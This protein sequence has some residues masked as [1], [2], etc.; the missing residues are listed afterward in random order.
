MSHGRTPVWWLVRFE[1][2]V[3]IGLTLLVAQLAWDSAMTMCFCNLPVRPL[4][5]PPNAIVAAT[6]LATAV[7]GLTW[8]VRVFR[9]STDEPPPWRYRDG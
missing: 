2:A 8:M 9:G 6:A 5:L 1:L 7:A 4:P 3:G